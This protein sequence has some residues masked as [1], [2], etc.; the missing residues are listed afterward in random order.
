MK[1]ILLTVFVDWCIDRKN[2]SGISNIKV[3][4]AYI[5]TK[6]HLNLLN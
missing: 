3:L 6:L 1:C 4:Y 5:P 2:M